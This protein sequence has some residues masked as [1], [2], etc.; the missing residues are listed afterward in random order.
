MPS[1]SW[2]YFFISWMSVSGS[3]ED[4]VIGYQAQTVTP[5]IMHPNAAAALPSTRIMPAVLSI[6]SIQK[7][8]ALGRCAAA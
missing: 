3:D 1:A 4:G 8:S 5:A 6:G 7:G 2:R